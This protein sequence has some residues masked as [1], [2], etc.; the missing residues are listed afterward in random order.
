[1]CP[2]NN[3]HTIIELRSEDGESFSPTEAYANTHIRFQGMDFRGLLNNH[4]EGDR[5][6]WNVTVKY[7]G[8]YQSKGIDTAEAIDIQIDE[9]TSP[10]TLSSRP[11]GG[12]TLGTAN[13]DLV[14]DVDNTTGD[15][16]MPCGFF[17]G[18]HESL[19]QTC[20]ISF[21]NWHVRL[22]NQRIKKD[23]VIDDGPH[24]KSTSGSTVNAISHWVLR[25]ELTPY[26][27]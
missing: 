14:N 22:L 19:T 1:M 4:P 12:L 5:G 24:L 2:N 11:T 23:G 18:A 15:E 3:Q 20:R 10:F 21:T 26:L 9:I 25:L 13:A 27:E 6:L 16:F 8:L 17:I 7:F